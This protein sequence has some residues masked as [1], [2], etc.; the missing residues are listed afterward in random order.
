MTDDTASPP[1]TQAPAL[2]FQDTPAW[3]L[4]HHPLAPH[5][6]FEYTLGSPKAIHIKAGESPMAY[7]NKGQFYP[8]T[9]RTPAGGKGLT[10]SSSKVKVCGA[11]GEGWGGGAGHLLAEWWD[12]AGCWA[13]LWEGAWCLDLQTRV[14]RLPHLQSVVMVVFDNDKVPVEQLRFWR[15]WHSR[16]PT[17]KQRVIDVGKSEPRAF[18]PAPLP[19]PAPDQSQQ[20]TVQEMVPSDGSSSYSFLLCSGTDRTWDADG[21]SEWACD[22]GHHGEQQWG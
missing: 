13:T 6:D 20:G 10:L 9:L 16:Q 21:A 8:V 1:Q 7:L 14:T 5:S 17:A 11:V 15:H 22:V 2:C 12:K 4:P 19:P 3:S 18:P